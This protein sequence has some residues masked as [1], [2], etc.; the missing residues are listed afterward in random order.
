MSAKF[1][2]AYPRH[3]QEAGRRQRGGRQGRA[4]DAAAAQYAAAR[5]FDHL[6]M[7]GVG[8]AVAGGAMAFSFFG[9]ARPIGRIT[10]PWARSPAATRDRDPFAARRD[11][12]GR[13]AAAVQVFK[14]NM[15]KAR[16]ARGRAGEAEERNAAQRKADMHKLADEFQAAVGRSSNGVVGLDRARSRGRHA[17]QDR[18]E[19]RRSSPA[20]VAAASEQASAN[21]QSVASPPRR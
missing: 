1:G 4:T 20:T 18:R 13:M 9:I 3:P 10:A 15:I 2:A 7:L 8:L 16:A 17:D 5:A 21:V 19:S 6:V 12:I 14:D 11:E